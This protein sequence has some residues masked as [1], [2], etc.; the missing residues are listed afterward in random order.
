[1]KKAVSR[2]V[3]LVQTAAA[4][5]FAAATP[6]KAVAAQ[7]TADG[8]PFRFCLNTGTLMGYKQP[9]HEVVDIAAK[10]GYDGIEPWSREIDAFIKSG[11]DLG[12]LAKRIRDQGLVVENVMSFAPWI[13]DDEQRRAEGLE[14]IKRE[15]EWTARLG[16]KRIAAPPAGATKQ[17][18]L[19]LLKAAERYR[20][21]LEL[22]KKFGVAPQLEIWGG[23]KTLGRLSEAVFVAVECGHPDAS[24]LLDV[25][26]LYKGG[27]DWRGLGLLN[28]GRLH[29]VHVNDYPAE[30]PRESITD[31]HRVY[32][33]DG[34]APL[35]E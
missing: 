12:D 24:L 6:L 7:T 16:G 20:A 23:S 3:M 35:Q 4:G 30:P 18:D 26:H 33:G 11:C 5:V 22:G 2:R 10:A 29:I 21:I 8:R 34:V 31:A 1:M 15:M 28:G 9:L 25:Y 32:P 27:S 13:V 14:T 19:S 17:T